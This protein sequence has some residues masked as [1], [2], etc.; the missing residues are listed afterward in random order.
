MVMKVNIGGSISYKKNGKAYENVDSMTYFSIEKEIPED[1]PEDKLRE[2]FDK[3][4]K[5]LAE[6]STRK[7]ILAYKTYKEKIT[8]IEELL[9]KE[10]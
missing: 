2:L 5:I 4:N 10:E 9:S 6:E 3:V 7:M 8:K 1:L